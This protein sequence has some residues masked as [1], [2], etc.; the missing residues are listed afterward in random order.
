MLVQGDYYSAVFL[1]YCIKCLCICIGIWLLT[2][3]QCLAVVVFFDDFS[4]GSLTNWQVARGSSAQ[5]R[6]ENGVL[7]GTVLSQSSISEVVPMDSA[8]SQ[9]WGNYR[10][11]LA[12]KPMRGVDRNL[13]WNYQDPRNWYEAHFVGNLVELYRL[14]EGVTGYVSGHQY[15][16]TPFEWHQIQVE[17][18]GTRMQLWVDNWLVADVRDWF[19]DGRAGSIAL[20]VGTG[21]IA[22]SEVWFDNVQ[23][24]L[25]STEHDVRIAMPEYR[26]DD[27][28]WS[29]NEYDHALSWSD[30]PS[31]KRWGCALSSIA[32]VLRHYGFIFLP[33]GSELH[34]G[35]LNQWLRHQPD[36]YVADGWVN[37]LAIERLTRVLVRDY[38]PGF[39]PLAVRQLHASD[40]RVLFDT[41]EQ[42]LMAMRPIIVALQ[43]HF[44]VAVGTISNLQD[45]LVL[46]PWYRVE[47]LGQHEIAQRA[48]KSLRRI[49][50]Y[51]L[52][53]FEYKPTWLLAVRGGGQP[54]V[55]DRE[56]RV[57]TMDWQQWLGPERG[58]ESGGVEQTQHTQIVSEWQVWQ[59]EQPAQGTY[60]LA[61]V[62][63]ELDQMQELRWYAYGLGD[64]VTLRVF[65]LELLQSPIE[66]TVNESL[67][68]QWPQHA[69][70]AWRHI[71]YWW[72]QKEVELLDQEL[73]SW[74]RIKYLLEIIINQGVFDQRQVQL[75]LKTVEY[76]RKSQ[77]SEV[78][79]EFERR[80][81]DLLVTATGL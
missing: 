16:M 73:E 63:S 34:P 35:T 7:I 51:S 41:V 28:Q 2:T 59:A 68:T 25:L 52:S 47:T 9:R 71:L 61:L 19:S 30:Q 24:E 50:P 23:V 78:L 43:Q 72:T 13:V 70:S 81:R 67:V 40:G 53:Q 8:W 48:I 55:Q 4:D 60:F 79:V 56:G 5:W 80:F 65:S 46:D 54:Q 76:Y 58:T 74:L 39:Q 38:F 29:D 49:E 77:P 75:I 11:R 31:I 12:M 33:D 6:V 20:K 57:I 17:V 66:V 22:P 26:Q 64:T 44:L 69:E 1:L 14:R 3:K 32:M 62:D 21:A 15:F 10:L 36:G 37:W 18:V 45:V 27:P 42:E